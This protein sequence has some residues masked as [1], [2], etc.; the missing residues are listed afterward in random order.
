MLTT[1]VAE[2]TSVDG[3]RM[4]LVGSSRRTLNPAQRAALR[5]SEIPVSGSGHAERTVLNAARLMGQT[6]R[7]IG[8]S[9]A[10]CAE[11]RSLLE[12]MGV[13]IVEYGEY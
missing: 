10:I 12:K 9:R 11:C 8:C 7:T 2:V 5:P 4:R 3:G 13:Q 1:A 6:V